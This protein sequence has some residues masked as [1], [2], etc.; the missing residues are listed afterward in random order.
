MIR[1]SFFAL[2][3]PPKNLTLAH[4]IEMFGH[5]TPFEL[6]LLLIFDQFDQ[7]SI[8]NFLPRKIQKRLSHLFLHR[9]AILA[10][11]RELAGGQGGYDLPILGGK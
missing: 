10:G 11:L 7:N 8:L 9:S 1:P 4:K 6:R 5:F 2:L 3:P